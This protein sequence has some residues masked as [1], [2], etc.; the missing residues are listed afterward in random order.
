MDSDRG[1]A[2]KSERH[3]LAVHGNYRLSGKRHDVFFVELSD[4]G[5][6]FY[7][8]YSPLEVGDDINL[9]IEDLGPF[10][11]TVRWRSAKYIGVQFE[12]PLYGPVFD[13]IRDKLDRAASAGF[14][15]RIPET[16]QVVVPLRRA[17]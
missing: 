9:R 1:E 11:A 15:P 12:T 4:K 13:H 3:G 14:I 2:R 16:D 10:G 7:D 5:C 6:R 17:S 8:R